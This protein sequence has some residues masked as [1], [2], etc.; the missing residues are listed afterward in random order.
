M[1]VFGASHIGLVGFF[2]VPVQIPCGNCLPSPALPHSLQDTASVERV[3]S[4]ATSLQQ[5]DTA[6]R[7]LRSV[8]VTDRLVWFTCKP[9][10]FLGSS[11]T[12]LGALQ[13]GDVVEG[14]PPWPFPDWPLA[15]PG[16][17]A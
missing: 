9:P 3:M 14:M 2:L 11:G 10:S 5:S 16:S 6:S 7:D 4:L 8:F 12:V 17:L 1:L 15:H 13:R